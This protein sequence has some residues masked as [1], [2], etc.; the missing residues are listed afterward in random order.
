MTMTTLV[1]PAHTI[2]ARHWRGETRATQATTASHVRS[3]SLASSLRDFANAIAI[4]G[5]IAIGAVV[6]KTLV[7]LPNFI[8]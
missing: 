8:H 1:S 3:G 5:T 6:L 7:W 4:F 2:L